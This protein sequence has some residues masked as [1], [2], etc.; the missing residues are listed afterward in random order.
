MKR[1]SRSCFGEAVW[2]LLAGL[3]GGIGAIGVTILLLAVQ[4]H[5][6]APPPSGYINPSAAVGTATETMIK[7]AAIFAAGVL[8]GVLVRLYFIRR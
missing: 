2:L 5:F 4:H 6:D 3:A 8:G 1:V 7:V